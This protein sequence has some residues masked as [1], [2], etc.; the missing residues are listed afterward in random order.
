MSILDSIKLTALI[1]LTSGSLE[2]VIGLI[3]DPFVPYPRWRSTPS[4]PTRLSSTT[5]EEPD[6][7]VLGLRE[8]M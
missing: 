1:A 5:L 8:G 3:H 6:R 7:A 2:I 4:V